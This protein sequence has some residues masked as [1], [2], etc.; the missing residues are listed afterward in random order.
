MKTRKCCWTCTARK[1][2]CDGALPTCMKCARSQRECEG[3]ELR[4]SWPREGDKKRALK[5][6]DAPA[7]MTIGTSNK[8]TVNPF[9]VNA[10]SHDMELYGYSS[11]QNQQCHTTPSF[12]RLL[13][14]PQLG[15]VHMDP[16]LFHHFQNFAYRSL[17]TFGQNT[18][19]I[20]NALMSMALARDTTSGLALF[21][22]LLAYASLHR[23]GLNE[24]A[25]KLKIQAIHYLSASVTSEALVLHVGKAA[26]HV[27]ASMVLGA[28]E[29]MQPSEGSGEWLWHTWGA[30]DMIHATQLKDEPHDS[31]VGHLLDWAYYHETQ[32]RFA[33][34]H[35]RHKSLIPSTSTK[36]HSRLQGLQ[37]PPL[38]RYRPNIPPVN[39]TYAILN[40]LSEVCDTLVDQRDPRSQN[41]SY[42]NRLK[43]LGGRV[44]DISVK[45]A[46]P[47][48]AD[49]DAAFAVELYQMATQ[50]Y[51]VRASQSPWEP[52]ANLDT[53][54]EAA[55]AGPVQSCSCEHFFPLLILACEAQRDEQRIGIINLIERTQRDVR[56]RSIQAV[57]NTI[58]SI[59]VQQDLHKDDD[60]LVDYLGILSSAIS[61][62]NTVPSFA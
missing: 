1:I 8:I 49:P 23:H 11:L 51:L 43:D 50:I 33:L 20:R 40:L 24:Q 18:G 53:L 29:I 42:Q 58:Q 31:G 47:S 59:W 60:V 15:V 16:D 39:P 22:A 21:H 4:L 62:S 37:Y 44:R 5:G 7:M 9:F 10:T 12:P 54:V 61:S 35:W 57:K 56:I 34:H 38:T 14:Q 6:I 48:T 45:T 3:Y 32:S 46:I 25:V 41:E 52:P 28:F 27:A 26:Q 17:V 13:R 19:K 30:V 55:F 36:Q 2:Q